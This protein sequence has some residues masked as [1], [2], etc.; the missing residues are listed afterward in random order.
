MASFGSVTIA[1][2]GTASSA[3]AIP[4]DCAVVSIQTPAAL[5]GTT[6]T[7]QGSQDGTNFGDVYVDGAVYAL[8]VTASKVYQIPPR[9]TIGLKEIKLVSGSAEAAART[10]LVSTAEVV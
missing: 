2:N 6:I 3:L 1:L 9:V 7:L 5:T 8:T 10:I 4:N